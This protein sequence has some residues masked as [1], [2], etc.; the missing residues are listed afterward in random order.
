MTPCV[1]WETNRSIHGGVTRRKHCYDKD[2]YKSTVLWRSLS[3]YCRH[4]TWDGRQGQSCGAF[5]SSPQRSLFQSRQLVLSFPASK[6]GISMT[7]GC[8]LCWR[9]LLN[10]EICGLKI[11]GKIQFERDKWCTIYTF[12]FHLIN[13]HYRVSEIQRFFKCT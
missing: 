1:V 8:A 4:S 12:S 13:V 2:G 6:A 7:T 9:D 10:R 3:Y 5:V 11:D